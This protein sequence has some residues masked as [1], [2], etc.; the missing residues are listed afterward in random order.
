VSDVHDQIEEL[1]LYMTESKFRDADISAMRFDGCEPLSTGFRA[2]GFGEDRLYPG[3]IPLRAGFDASVICDGAADDSK[4]AS[5]PMA[6]CYMVGR[7]RHLGY[8]ERPA[9]TR[10]HRYAVR[11]DLVFVDQQG[12]VPGW[13]TRGVRA[14]SDCVKWYSRHGDTQDSD[15]N[16]LGQI[17]VACSGIWWRA[18]R[19]WRVLLGSIGGPRLSLETGPTGAKELFR[20]RDIPQGKHRRA[21]LRHWVREHWRKRDGSAAAVRRH[22]RG[23]EEFTWHGL[24]GKICVPSE[25]MEADL[26]RTIAS[27]KSDALI[28]ERTLVGG[29]A[30]P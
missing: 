10:R 1:V 12:E 6:Q 8:A 11:F 21:A 2:T 22:L 26:E 14:T 27:L 16:K 3:N 20:L 23:S 13:W 9:W 25:E 15:T 17:T 5:T 24:S 28:S 30:A 19:T 29:A 7:A 4:C 18:Q